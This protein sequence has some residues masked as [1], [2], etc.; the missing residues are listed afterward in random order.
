MA[1]YLGDRG[2]VP[3]QWVR[4]VKDIKAIE[5]CGR[6]QLGGKAILG[7]ERLESG[8]KAATIV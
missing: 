5:S 3:E 6:L 7:C 2:A 4:N 1:V 8:G